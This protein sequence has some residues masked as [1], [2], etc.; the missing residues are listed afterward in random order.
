MT[1]TPP[2]R[3]GKSGRWPG[4]LL[5]PLALLAGA[6]G[7][8][9]IV[10]VARHVPDYLLPPP[11]EIWQSAV[12]QHQL[13]WDNTL[14]TL[15]IA[16]SGFLLALVLGL[17][18]AIAI[19]YSRALELALYP[20]VIATQTVPVIALAPI[21]VV[22][23]G[24]GLMPKLIVVC[25]ICFFP[26]TVNAVDGFKSVDPDLVNLMRTLGA[27]RGRIFRDIEWP[28][29]LPFIFSGARVAITYCVIGALYGELV[30][31]FE[32]LG[33]LMQQEQSQFN[34]PLI[35]AAMAV[36]SLM[37]MG[38]FGLVALAERLL[39]PWHRE[40]GG[41]ALAGDAGRH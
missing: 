9:Q 3:Q 27:G 8:W 39:L 14:P 29:A 6:V 7:V 28:S 32:G 31:S 16:L 17:A 40:P 23:L 18:L 10:T 11:A 19:R 1:E 20:I 24:F 5:P 12:D 33:W 26:I 21:L 4:R 36:L 25:L 30:G 41:D 13:L 35:F 37:G 22:L 38:L 34:T 2:R 15:R